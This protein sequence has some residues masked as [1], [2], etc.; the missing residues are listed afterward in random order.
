MFGRRCR[1]SAGHD[2]AGRLAV[3]VNS[4]SDEDASFFM[5][6]KLDLRWRAIGQEARLH[7]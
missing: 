5:L 4:T 2:H 7:R 1:R 3:R 6:T